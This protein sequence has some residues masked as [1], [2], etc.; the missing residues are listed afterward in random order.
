MTLSPAW[1]FVSLLIG[2]AGFALFIYG[3]K[4]GRVPQLVAGLVLMIYPYFISS[5]LWTC[6]VALAILAG[7]WWAVRRGW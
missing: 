1:L 3:K 6:V 7:L 5:L 2:G 4:Q